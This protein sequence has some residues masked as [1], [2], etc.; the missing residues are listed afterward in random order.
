MATLSDSGT[1]V[2]SLLEEWMQGD[3]CLCPYICY[4]CTYA[5]VYGNLVPFIV[6][7]IFAA[8]I[9][10]CMGSL[11]AAYTPEVTSLQNSPLFHHLCCRV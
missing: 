7:L 4:M 3:N 1:W 6:Y 8:E 9:E 11:A 5:V 10:K 2:W